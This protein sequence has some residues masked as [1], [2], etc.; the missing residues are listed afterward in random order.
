MASQLRFGTFLT[1]HFA[2]E[3]VALRRERE[4]AAEQV[5]GASVI[6]QAEVEPVSA[7]TEPSQPS[8]IPAETF[9]LRRRNDSDL[10]MMLDLGRDDAGGAE[11]P[12][13]QIIV[14]ALAAVIAL[15]S[16]A[17]LLLGS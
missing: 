4:R 16:A 3:I 8:V 2:E 6:P 11:R 17:W 1:D 12:R 15:G 10:D 13:W 5:L 14:A 7:P 9:T